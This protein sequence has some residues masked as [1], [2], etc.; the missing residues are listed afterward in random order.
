[1]VNGWE[2]LPVVKKYISNICKFQKNPIVL[3]ISENM[4]L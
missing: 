4:I 1:M 2:Y 3:Q